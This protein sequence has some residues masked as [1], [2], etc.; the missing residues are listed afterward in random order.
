MQ[1]GFRA[2][3]SCVQELVKRAW[4]LGFGYRRAHVLLTLSP[5]LITGPACNQQCTARGSSSILF[6]LIPILLLPSQV[7][8]VKEVSWDR[9]EELATNIKH[10]DY[11]AWVYDCGSGMW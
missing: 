10:L 6:L 9:W 1:L 3:A 8:L 2:A 7:Q 5:R 4:A 11:W